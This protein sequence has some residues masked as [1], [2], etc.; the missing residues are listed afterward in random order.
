MILR[1]NTIT[2]FFNEIAERKLKTS[3]FDGQSPLMIYQI[4]DKIFQWCELVASMSPED[5]NLIEV[6]SM[7]LDN[8]FYVY[9]DVKVEITNKMSALT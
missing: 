3:D 7:S 9:T 8:L 1:L 5:Y 6:M 2:L 4:F